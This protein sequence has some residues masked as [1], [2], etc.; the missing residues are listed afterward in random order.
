MDDLPDELLVMICQYALCPAQGLSFTGEPSFWPEKCKVRCGNQKSIAV[1]LFLASRRL[2]GLAIPVVYGE[3]TFCFDTEL[4][5]V[6]DFF[7]TLPGKNLERIK[8]IY[9]RGRLQPHAEESIDGPTLSSATTFLCQK[10][11]LDCFSIA[12]PQSMQMEIGGGSFYRHS[13]HGKLSSTALC[14]L[15][16]GRLKEVHFV[17]KGQVNPHPWEGEAS[18]FGDDIVKKYAEHIL[19]DEKRC[20]DLQERRRGCIKWKCGTAADIDN[21]EQLEK[22]RAAYRDM[23]KTVKAVWESVGVTIERKSSYLT[24]QRSAVVIKRWKSNDSVGI[25]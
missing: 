4:R 14:M 11:F 17:Q 16:S 23:L 2:S 22:T 18:V 19:L 12:V 5:A 25:R 20:K 7:V 9:L 10:M 15:Q 3:N 21:K 24:T 8:R 6:V 1:G 13:N